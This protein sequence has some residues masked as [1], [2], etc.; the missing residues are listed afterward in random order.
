MKALIIIAA[1]ILLSVV[2]KAAL[3]FTERRPIHSVGG[4]ANIYSTEMA[5]Y[6][7]NDPEDVKRAMEVY[8]DL[9]D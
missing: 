9:A 5:K 7:L 1:C 2:L 4:K 3:Y 6:D 8:K